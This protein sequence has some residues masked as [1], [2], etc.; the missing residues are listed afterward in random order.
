M[1]RCPSY[2]ALTVPSNQSGFVNYVARFSGFDFATA[3]YALVSN[4]QSKL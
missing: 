2:S 3:D 1:L 4:G